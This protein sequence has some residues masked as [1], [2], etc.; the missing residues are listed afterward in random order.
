[1]TRGQGCCKYNQLTLRATCPNM[2]FIER[3]R[4]L[5]LLR[6]YLQIIILSTYVICK[7]IVI[8]CLYQKFLCINEFKA[9]Q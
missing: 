8:A 3:K 1:M 4:W 7:E 9:V 6:R 5:Q 2:I